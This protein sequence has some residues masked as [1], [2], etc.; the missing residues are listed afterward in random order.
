MSA[1]TPIRGWL[2][3]L[4]CRLGWSGRRLYPANPTLVCND[5]GQR[6]RYIDRMGEWQGPARL[7]PCGHRSDYHGDASWALQSAWLSLVDLRLCPK[8]GET[9]LDGPFAPFIQCLD[10]GLCFIATDGHFALDTIERAQ[11]RGPDA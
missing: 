4:L 10:D 7:Q 8:C 3:R 5:C 11:E 6:V 9:V 1:R 2:I